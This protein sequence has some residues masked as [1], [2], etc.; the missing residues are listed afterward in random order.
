MAKFILTNHASRAH[1]GG[2]ISVNERAHLSCVSWKSEQLR[3]FESSTG[4]PN[5][6]CLFP[7][8]HSPPDDPVLLCLPD[9]DCPRSSF[10]SHTG[11]SYYKGSSIKLI[12]LCSI[13][14]PAPVQWAGI[15]HGDKEVILSLMICDSTEV[16]QVQVAFIWGQGSHHIVLV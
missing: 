9:S 16:V 13:D 12:P 7:W 6:P 4:V 5:S 8:V 1:G 10:W 15:Q 14:S 11:L 2:G 3:A